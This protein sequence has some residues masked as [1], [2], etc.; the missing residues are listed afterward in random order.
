VN[1]LAEALN[2]SPG[3]EATTVNIL[4]NPREGATTETAWQLHHE[5]LASWAMQR[6]VNRDD[7]YGCYGDSGNAYT[8]DKPLSKA[9]LNT[10]FGAGM[11]VGLHSTSA[12]ET[13]RWL[14]FDLDNHDKDPEVAARN[15]DDAIR[16]C[17]QLTELG[18]IWLLEDSNGDGGFH[19]WILFSEPA[20]VEAV[21]RF[22]KW[23]LGDDDHEMFPKQPELTGKGLGN[24]LR[25][26]GRHHKRDHSSRFWGGSDWL[27]DAESVELLIN[28]PTNDLICLR[29][30]PNEEESAKAGDLVGRVSDPEKPLPVT[31]GTSKNIVELAE[32]YIEQQ[33]WHDILTAEGWK[34]DSNHDGQSSWTRPGK[35]SGT[36]ATL[37]FSGN[38]KIHIFSTGTNVPAD[39][40]YGKFRF[41]AYSRGF[42]DRSQVQAAKALLPDEV[43]AENN[44]QWRESSKSVDDLRRNPSSNEANVDK[45]RRKKIKRDDFTPF[46]V[47][48]LPVVLRAFVTESATA[49]GCDPTMALMPALGVCAAAIGTSRNLLVKYGWFVPSVLWPVVIG[50]SGSQKSPPYRLAVE[51]LKTRQT[52]QGEQYST[53]LAA[54]QDDMKQY[55]RDLKQ[56]ERKPEG[57]AP[58]EPTKPVRPRCLVADATL[59]ALAPILSDN[60]RGVLLG[61]DELSGW[62]SGFDKYNNT[63]GTSANV[64]GWLESYNAGSIEIDRKTGDDRFISVPRAAVSITGGIQPG[65]LA[66]V[67]TAEHKANGLQS[68]LLMTFPPRQPKRWRDEEISEGTLQIYQ[69]AVDELFTL[70]PNTDADG[71]ESPALLRLT[72]DARDIYK[73]FVNTHGV[74]QNAMQG[75]LASQWSKLEEIP[76][77]LAIIIHCLRQVTTGV[78]DYFKVDDRTMAAAVTMTEWFKTECLRINRLLTEP[79]EEREARHLTEWIRGQ[80]GRITARDLC[81]RR[82]DIESTEEAES[83]L[84]YLAS[85]Q[86]GSWEGIHK[87]RVFV[88][89]SEVSTIEA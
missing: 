84:V 87:S 12:D 38:D 39:K 76:P 35:N 63:G 28:A 53:E 16:I 73:R 68:R 66:K 22:G 18:I 7:R 47:D 48:Q 81:R 23:L 43:V 24:W 65:I 61:R 5:K 74:E 55:K 75:H 27:D 21:H 77:R 88:L 45:S 30:A 34:P 33:L 85:I 20:P 4:T 49:I 70:K 19:I 58:A 69:S 42:N 67:L 72:D 31:N 50:E 36:S 51:P 13:C 71:R 15:F 62:I 25:L 64:Q 14:A 82:R 11:L 89:G 6:L 57:T 41:W 56:W 80:G 37:N 2:R 26:P 78:V 29:H 1:R 83:K 52:S 10:H 60:P 44:R 79:D 9:S 3:T 46:P 32:E 54:Y 40:S 59:E 17:N 86:A 8:S